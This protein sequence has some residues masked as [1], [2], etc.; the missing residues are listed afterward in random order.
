LQAAA[1]A[2]KHCLVVYP[3]RNLYTWIYAEIERGLKKDKEETVH[4]SLLAA[5]EF[6]MNTG[7]F[8]IHTSCVAWRHLCFRLL[9]PTWLSAPRA[10]V[11]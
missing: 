2:L 10:H 6:I 9:G 4:G 7:T 1:Y 3:G 11:A 8:A 5:T